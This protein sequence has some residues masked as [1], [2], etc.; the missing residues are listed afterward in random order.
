MT[1]YWRYEMSPFN[2]VNWL[3]VLVA[4]ASGIVAVLYADKLE[5]K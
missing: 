2:V 4:L 1:A 5:G 3:A